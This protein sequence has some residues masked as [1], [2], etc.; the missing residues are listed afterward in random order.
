M[1]PDAPLILSIET[2]TPICSVCVAR[3]TEVLAERNSSLG[4]E[5]ASVLAS[6][7]NDL[8]NETHFSV[9][10]LSAIAVSE[11][12]GS[13]T[14]LRIGLSTAKGMCY[15]S[16]IPLILINTLQGMA[17][18][19]SSAK[20]DWLIPVIDAR[21]NDVYW[22]VF[23]KSGE[24]FDAKEC[25]NVDEI[26]TYISANNLKVAIAGTGAQKFADAGVD[27]E[28]LNENVI[29]AKNLIPLALEKHK[30]NM[31]AELAY[32]EPVYRKN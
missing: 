8:F 32:A 21:R 14:G 11:G 19:M 24:L 10:D 6:F 30:A 20:S 31:F 27:V 17:A 29:A 4:N 28:R 26:A 13:Y 15:A 2:A 7:I 25:N 5:H 9:K 22:S 23:K 1:T 3:G 16:G 18:G 12:P